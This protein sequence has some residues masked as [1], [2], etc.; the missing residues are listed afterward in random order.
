MLLQRQLSHQGDSPKRLY[1]ATMLKMKG[2]GRARFQLL[3]RKPNREEVNCDVASRYIF[4]RG[5]MRRLLLLRVRCIQGHAG[6][7]MRNMTRI[8]Q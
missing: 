1:E 4:D 7:T 6:E 5:A 8:G 2:T 3:V